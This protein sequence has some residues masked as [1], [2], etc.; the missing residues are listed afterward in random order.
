MNM[1]NVTSVLNSA[2]GPTSIFVAAKSP[3]IT[4]VLIAT[5]IVGVIIALF[6]LKIV[7]V[8]SAIVGLGT[9]A[10]I[11]AVV[12]MLFGLDTTKMLVTIAVCGLVLGI[13]CAV[14]RK[15]G[16]FV[17]T[18][19]GSFG[20]FVTLLETKSLIVLGICAAVAL[21]VAILTVIFAEFL[22]IFVTGIMGGV[23]AGMA[24]PFVLG[25]TKIS[26]IGYVLSAAIAVIGIVVQTMMQSR[27]IGKKE[28]IFSKKIK[29][30]V[31]MESEVEKARML[32]DDGEPDGSSEEE[33]EEAE[34]GSDNIESM[35]ASEET[36]TEIF[37][38]DDDKPEAIEEDDDVVPAGAID[39]PEGGFLDEDEVEI[40]ET[41]DSDVVVLHADDIDEYVKYP[42]RKNKIRNGYFFAGRRY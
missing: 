36:V 2:D 9:G 39:E 23:E 27:K 33:P 35:E 7:R 38:I 12:A 30:Q 40:F 42:L 16:I 10:V 3:E 26:W 24:L 32:L 1:E 31:S 13:M 20:T 19:F 15:F 11:G 41:D 29:E 17:M 25:M 14:L 6:G 4:G 34:A 21:I 8:L 28:K 22:V 5:V 37:D 18:F